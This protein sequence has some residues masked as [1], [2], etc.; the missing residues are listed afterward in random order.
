MAWTAKKVAEDT[1]YIYL[2]FSEPGNTASPVRLPVAKP[3]SLDRV[4][5][6]VRDWIAD[7]AASGIPDNDTIIPATI[8]TP[9]EPTQEEL[10]LQ[11]FLVKVE[12]ARKL[13]SVVPADDQ[14]LTDL[15]AE[16][17]LDLKGHPKWKNSL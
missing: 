6:I 13:E 5:E 1:N 8:P 10:D 12:L 9:T 2:E 14:E 3:V 16:I 4:R 17:A 15:K 11:A 7:H